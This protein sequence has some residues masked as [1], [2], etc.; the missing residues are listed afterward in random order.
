MPEIASA[1]VTSGA[2]LAHYTKRDLR[3]FLADEGFWTQQRLPITRRRALSQVANP[4]AEE[5]DTLLIAAY[6]QDQLVAYVGI[7]PD[8]LANGHQ[9]LKFGWLTAWW[10]DKASGHRLAGLKV[11]LSAMKKYSNRLA[12]SFPSPDA[13]SVYEATKQ[14]RECVRVG[15]S[16]FIISPPPQFGALSSSAR[17]LAGAKNRLLFGRKL[18]MRGLEMRIVDMLDGPLAALIDTWAINDPLRRDSSY[19]SWVLRFPWMSAD[20]EDEAA[21]KRY[22]FSAF[23]R[24]FRQVLLRVSREGATLALLVMTLRDGRLCLK[25]AYYDSRDAAD[26]AA[27]TRAAISDINPWLFISSDAGLNAEFERGVPFY[28]A[29]R[30][31]SSAIYSAKALPLSDGYCRQLGTGDSIF[32]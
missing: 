18:R 11:L 1:P 16:Y 14:F 31:K 9:D 32:T 12:A 24:D 10:A 20:A 17:W 4:R 25:H 26:V 7:L 13:E 30:I 27:T 8:L 5:N 19:W 29:K 22:A 3:E 21:Q 6:N 15:R 28:L 2:T 23:A